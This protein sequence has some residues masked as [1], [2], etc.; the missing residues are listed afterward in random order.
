MT[1]AQL[2]DLAYS[3]PLMTPMLT[4]GHA[5]IAGASCHMVEPLQRIPEPATRRSNVG[6]YDPEVNGYD[7]ACGLGVRMLVSVVA[8]GGAPIFAARFQE[9]NKFERIWESK[10]KYYNQ[11]YDRSLMCL[12]TCMC[13]CVPMFGN[14]KHFTHVCTTYFVLYVNAICSVS[15]I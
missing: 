11:A 1:L 3:A 10:L 2:S 6:E 7:L 4:N 9:E 12:F 5:A 14:G 15:I 8:A 13:K